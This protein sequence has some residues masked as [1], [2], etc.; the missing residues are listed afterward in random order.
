MK[1]HFQD[2]GVRKWAGDDLIELQSEPL[3]ALQA[4]VS[5]Y[6]PCI[7]SGC[8]V[9]TNDAGGYTISAGLVALPGKD[10]KGEDCVK[11]VR[12]AGISLDDSQQVCY[13]TLHHQ[14]LTRTY[15]DGQSKAIAYDYT[16]QQTTSKPV[17]IPY[18]E[19]SVNG[20]RRLVDALAITQ[21]LDREGGEA[22]DVKVTFAE[23]SSEQEPEELKSGTKLGVLI[24]NIKGWLNR[25]VDKKEGYILS[26]NDFTDKL[27]EK[28]ER[29]T[30]AA[31]GDLE[32]NYPNPTIKDSVVLNGFPVVNGGDLVVASEDPYYGNLRL[33]HSGES[34][35]GRIFLGED[36]STYIMRNED[37]VLEITSYSGPIVLNASEGI[38]DGQD[39]DILATQGFVKANKYTHPT[40]NGNNHIPSDGKSGEYLKYSSSGT[41]TWASPASNV[42]SPSA[43]GFM[44]ADDKD[45][46]NGI[47][48]N[49]NNYSLSPATMDTLGGVKLG[50]S[51]TQ[52]IAAVAPQSANNRTYPTQ[53]DK[54]GRLVVNVPWTNTVY[55][56][57]NL[58][59]IPSNG[60]S[61]QYLKY[62]SSGTAAWA[63]PAFNIA[64]T[65]AAGFMSAADK[66][67]LDK[68]DISISGNKLTITWESNM[69]ASGIISASPITYTATLSGSSSALPGG[70]LVTQ[71]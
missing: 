33:I 32:G 36:E 45:K 49:A 50:S 59:H 4:L 61:G 26:K 55:T 44:S 63:S 14:P 57:P 31:G 20:G 65:S 27:K 71:P 7:I 38:Y 39:G 21:K 69:T 58:Q 2:Y 6:A 67:K 43:A 30:H 19:I 5:P 46:L 54:N 62:S 18:L 37:G 25:K 3:A 47:A 51:N 68:I 42:A 1:E 52:S 13:L 23:S 10:F 53:L 28:L 16:A 48:K 22:K 11:I 9:K 60:S 64:T 56:H 12:T 24:S 41:A 8:K 17:D 15:K 35:S 40:G 34:S 29:F 70:G 66:T